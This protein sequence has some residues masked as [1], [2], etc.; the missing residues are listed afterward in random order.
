M[1]ASTQRPES[2][3]ISNEKHEY[4]RKGISDKPPNN[5]SLK[6]LAPKDYIS[7]S[8]VQGFLSELKNRFGNDFKGEAKPDEVP[9]PPLIVSDIIDGDGNQYVNLVQK[10]GG[11]L[12]I[13]LV[14]YTFIL[15][16]AGVRFMR[17]AGTSA[18]A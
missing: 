7:E 14:G 4:L 9:K 3:I 13:A 11:V 10:G 2:G 8:R 12:G 17:M 6:T 15:E 18:G 5:T 1:V 16:A